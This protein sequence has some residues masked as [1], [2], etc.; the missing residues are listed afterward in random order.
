MGLEQFQA[1]LAKV[2]T[3][4]AVR[5]ALLQDPAAFAR[6][7][8]LTREETALLA[9]EQFGAFAAALRSKRRQEASRAMP[10]LEQTFG[11]RL[12]EL[13]DRFAAVNAGQR[14]PAL[15]ALAFHHWLLRTTPLAAEERRAVQV[16][17]DGL[18]MR[19]T[20]R[21]FC[22]RLLHERGGGL[23]VAVWWRW[24]GQLRHRVTPPWRRSGG[25]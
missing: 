5:E 21:R 1:A 20:A 23:S 19:H 10:V 15:D 24:R 18:T 2:C 17:R 11:S 9:E 6:E 13:F 14:S 8:G 25:R 16:S 22:L 12:R 4:P 7:H 3:R